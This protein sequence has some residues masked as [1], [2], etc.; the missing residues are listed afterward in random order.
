[1]PWRDLN[2]PAPPPP[3]PEPDPGR[4]HLCILASGSGGNCS[5]LRVR[6]ETGRPERTVLLDAGISPTRTRRLLADRGIALGEIDDIVLTH[7]DADHF[8]PGWRRVRDCRATLR[9]HRR[10]LGKAQ[11]R[12]L[13]LGRNEPFDEAFELGAGV[14]IDPIL[15]AHDD[16]GVAAFRV[17][18]GTGDSLGFATDL[19]RATDALTRHL[20]GVGVL[21]IESNYCPVMQGESDRPAFLKQRITGGA[22]HLSN[23]ECAQA[24]RAIGPASAVVLLHLSRQCNTPDLARRAHDGAPYALTLA[25]QTEPT[26]WVPLAPSGEPPAVAVRAPVQGLLFARAAR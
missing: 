14:R 20:A 7:L 26:P 17:E 19:G 8:H 3:F 21:A 4:A 13:L 18:T 11:R 24:V 22:G 10:H 2:R 15:M 12:G 9:L 25:H 16:L 23:E 5:V 6:S 1:M